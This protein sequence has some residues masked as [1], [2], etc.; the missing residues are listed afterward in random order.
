MSLVKINK[1][2]G[3]VVIAIYFLVCMGEAS[4]H[5]PVFFFISNTSRDGDICSVA[6]LTGK[7]AEGLP[8]VSKIILKL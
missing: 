6:G 4:Q 2:K 7:T 3:N 5:F 8:S 1:E